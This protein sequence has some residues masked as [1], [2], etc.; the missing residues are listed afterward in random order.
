MDVK[1]F[2]A[3]PGA[4]GAVRARAREAGAGAHA[5]RLRAITVFWISDVPS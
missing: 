1:S 3:G 2:I 5:S 4:W